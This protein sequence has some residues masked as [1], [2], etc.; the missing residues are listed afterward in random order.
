M[1][2][3]VSE[4]VEGEILSCLGGEVAKGAE[5]MRGEIGM[6]SCLGGGV[7]ETALRGEIGMGSG[8]GGEV[9]N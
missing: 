9:D 1:G 2:I 7:V 6:G 5:V 8:L 3:A 4:G